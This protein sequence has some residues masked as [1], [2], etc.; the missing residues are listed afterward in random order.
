MVYHH[1]LFVSDKFVSNNST[2]WYLNSCL[3]RDIR[4]IDPGAPMTGAPG[5]IGMMCTMFGVRHSRIPT[6]DPA[7]RK[8]AESCGVELIGWENPAF[9]DDPSVDD[10]MMAPG[11]YFRHLC[12]DVRLRD[13]P[14]QPKIDIIISHYPYFHA[15]AVNLKQT[16]FQKAELIIFCHT[17]VERPR[18]LCPVDSDWVPA[19]IFSIGRHIYGQNRTLEQ[20]YG[21]HRSFKGHYHF[22]PRCPEKYLCSFNGPSRDQLNKV[23]LSMVTNVVH[24]RGDPIED[25]FRAFI[26][27]HRSYHDQGLPDVAPVWRLKAAEEDTKR[28]LDRV[29][30]TAP[31]NA[32][33]VENIQTTMQQDNTI[34]DIFLE[35]LEMATTYIEVPSGENNHVALNALYALGAGVPVLME[36][37]YIVSSYLEQLNEELDVSSFIVPSDTGQNRQ[38]NWTDKLQSAIARPRHFYALARKIRKALFL[39]ETTAKSRYDFLTCLTGESVKIHPFLA[40]S[41]VSNLQTV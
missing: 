9:T 27:T 6:L 5:K 15:A 34:D 30:K 32:T 36:S 28:K 1:I 24:H 22:S 14:P 19:A 25:I 29:S 4:R 31:A 2:V 39:D 12:Q 21:T 3:A 7:E 41:N 8:E 10:V 33:T 18:D 37:D 23:F 35:S 11:N 20:R 17:P 26:Q 13:K 16:I 40:R 38:K